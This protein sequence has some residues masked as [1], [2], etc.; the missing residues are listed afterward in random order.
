MRLPTTILAF[1]GSICLLHADDFKKSQGVWHVVSVTDDGQR[2][3][4]ASAQRMTVI[5]AANRYTVQVGDKIVE[6]GTFVLDPSKNPETIDATVTE[7]AGKG[8]SALG[9]Y[10]LGDQTRTVCL[11]PPGAARPTRF[12]SHK[13]SRWAIFL[14]HRKTS[15]EAARGD[16]ERMQGK[17]QM[18]S[19]ER[20][21]KKL[22]DPLVKT[23]Q[24]IVKGNKYRVTWVEDGQPEVLDTIMA[25]DPRQE[26]KAVDILLGNGWFKGKKRLGIYRIDGDT[27]TVC[28]A[29]P[30]KARPTAFDSRQGAIHVW[31]RAKQ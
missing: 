28:L 29:Q 4:D 23:Y 19:M 18:V 20:D 13:G 17:W 7:G 24:R 2:L 12:E 14:T 26:P 16:L 9:I 27:E 30:G 5:I 25:V 31:A 3:S 8:K 10:A 21:G 11:A 15:E 1:M 22:P 6:R